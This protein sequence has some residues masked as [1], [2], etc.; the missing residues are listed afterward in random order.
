MIRDKGKQLELKIEKYFQLNGYQTKRNIVLEGKSGGKHEIDILAEKSDAVTTIKIMV[1]CKAWNK[2]VEKDVVSK[3]GYVLQDL[4]LNKAIIVTLMGWRIGAE[5]AAQKMGI[6]LWGPQ[7]IEKKLGKVSVQE[8]KVT[9]F[10]KVSVGFLLSIKKE[11]AISIIEKERKGFF[12]LEKED[13]A[14]IKLVDVPFYL[15]QITYGRIQGIISRKLFTK[16]IYNLYDALEG[17]FFKSYEEKPKLE[18]IKLTLPLQAK[19]KDSKVKKVIEEMFERASKVVTYRAQ[20]R[21]RSKLI[22][23]GIPLP[24]SSISIDEVTEVY[25][26]FYIA[27]LRRGEKERIIAVDGLEGNV[28]KSISDVLTKNLSYVL[29]SIKSS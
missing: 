13:I 11:E 3:V 7:E 14:W 16:K 9:E 21:Y 5:K 6:E 1:E 25:Y 15:F 28:I 26:P 12:G 29:E 20:L 23:L 18:E 27:L 22:N 17:S 19:I 2:P 4:G 8:L 10:K 24:V